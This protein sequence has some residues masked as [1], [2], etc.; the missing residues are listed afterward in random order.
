[1]DLIL[2]R[3][4]EIYY[5]ECEVLA[6]CDFGHIKLRNCFT[7][8]LNSSAAKLP[9]MGQMLLL[10]PHC[11]CFS[12]VGGSDWSGLLGA[13]PG[14]EPAHNQ[15][16]RARLKSQDLHITGSGTTTGSTETV[17]GTLGAAEA[18]RHVPWHLAITVVYLCC[19]ALEG[20][21]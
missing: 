16:C 3:S 14:A 13:G 15:P 12:P 20:T 8:L 7:K 6:C 4:R 5:L 21:K 2:Y 18:S 1:M 10:P 19:D 11:H 9:L 17:S